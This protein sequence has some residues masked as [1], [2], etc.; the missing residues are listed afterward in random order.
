MFL[1]YFSTV[2]GGFGA[3]GGVCSYCGE[4][5]V[6]R[7]VPPFCVF[8][9]AC[10]RVSRFWWVGWVSYIRD[11]LWNS[12]SPPLLLWWVFLYLLSCWSG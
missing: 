10:S 12:W 5:R 1:M 8:I 2:L 7:I 4:V 6:S 9:S 11:F 3:G